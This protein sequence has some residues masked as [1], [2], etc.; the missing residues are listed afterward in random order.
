[1][2]SLKEALAKYLRY[3]RVPPRKEVEG[4]ETFKR[5]ALSSFHSNAV[6]PLA[7]DQFG[8]PGGA[9]SVIWARPINLAHV[10]LIYLFFVVS[11]KYA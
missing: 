11:D 9:G 7:T 5:V 1:L 10:H 3:D 2:T 8:R 6:T 4:F